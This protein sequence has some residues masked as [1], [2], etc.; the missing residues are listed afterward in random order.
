[1]L[2]FGSLNYKNDTDNKD[3]KT[4]IMLINETDEEADAEKPDNS[5]AC[6]T[7]KKIFEMIEN[8]VLV[9]VDE[10]KT[11][12]CEAKDFCI[13]V[14]KNKYTSDYIKELQKLGINAKGEEEKGYLK[15]REV[16]VLL[17]L[18]RIIDNPLLDIS[19]TAV[20]MS[21]MYMFTAQDLA[22]IRIADKDSYILL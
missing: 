9:R 7:A 3:N 12:P 14:R 2:Y 22:E 19:I 13:L 10:H 15:S 18:L 4:E 16:M 20:M 5:E 8:K 17:D 11:R 6:I 21:P 1:M